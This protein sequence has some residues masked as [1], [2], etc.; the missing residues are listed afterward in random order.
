MTTIIDVL[1]ERH[2]QVSNSLA[3]QSEITLKSYV[4]DDFRKVLILSI[5]S[6]FEHQILE[7]VGGLAESAESRQLE[8]LVKSKAIERQYHTYFDWTTKNANKFLS[9]FG[10][11]FKSEV[12]NEIKGDRSLDEGCRSFLQLG[13]TRNILVHENFAEQ[14]LDFSLDE[15]IELY[16]KSLEFVEFL[17]KKILPEGR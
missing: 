2:E 13:N 11:D 10:Q 9:L 6:Y 16:R 8:N 15:I 4:D 17:S 14:D 12:S 3:S 7:A 5:A 1:I